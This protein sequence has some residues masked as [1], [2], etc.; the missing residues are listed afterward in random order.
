ML[1]DNKKDQILLVLCF[2]F[3]A[4]PSVILKVCHL[5]CFCKKVSVRR[6]LSSEIQKYVCFSFTF[7]MVFVLLA[8]VFFSME[9]TAKER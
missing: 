2:V 5:F 3:I 6:L 8:P 4:S 1:T 7:F 9:K